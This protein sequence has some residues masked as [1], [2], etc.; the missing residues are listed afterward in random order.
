MK[1]SNRSS[2]L[3]SSPLYVFSRKV[4]EQEALGREIISLGLGEPFY[5][6]PEE[7]KQ[8]GIRAIENN[9]THYNPATGSMELR[10]TLAVIHGVTPEHISVSSGAKPFLGAVFWSLVDEGDIVYMAGPYYPPFLQIAESC[11]AKVVL[12]DTK[13]TGLR[14]TADSL[15]EAIDANRHNQK[16]SYII[17][18]SPNNPTGVVYEKAELEKIVALCKQRG[19]TIISDE[20]YGKL[21]ADPDFGLRNFSEDVIVINSLSKSHAMTGWR[22]GYVICPPELNVIVGRFL[23]NY[24]GCPSSISDAAALVALKSE[25]L[26]DLV[27]QRE[28]VHGWLERL[29]IPHTKSE[30]GIFI[31]PDFAEIM[32][33]KGIANSVDLATYF[34]EEAGVATTPGVS[35]GEKYDAHLRISYCIETPKLALALEKLEK[36][37]R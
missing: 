2:C 18:N 4:K 27:G 22:I 36:V 30:G 19:I 11:G 10:K 12:I 7:I 25:P 29:G 13:P 16:K 35:F 9:K 31:F 24:I 26:P 15:K 14:L 1:F 8:A 20:C 32:K 33:K 6:T 3:T 23:E 5:D 28:L 37:I 21:S 17:I 34:L